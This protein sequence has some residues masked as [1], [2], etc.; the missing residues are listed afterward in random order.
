VRMP[1][2]SRDRERKAVP[3]TR[4]SGVGLRSPPMSDRNN[5]FPHL[6]LDIVHI[7]DIKL[8]MLPTRQA[9]M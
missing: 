1:G 5:F 7:V 8:C 2:P 9:H 3:R 6:K 4:D